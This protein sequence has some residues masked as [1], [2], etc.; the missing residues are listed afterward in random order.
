M[1]QLDMLQPWPLSAAERSALLAIAIVCLLMLWF[2]TLPAL[3]RLLAR[4][5]PRT[6]PTDAPSLLLT[7]TLTLAPR[8]ATRGTNGRFVK[9]DHAPRAPR[10]VSRARSSLL[11][12]LPARRRDV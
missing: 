10:K 3:A 9:A 6:V 11:P 12:H 1:I 2:V 5:W 8:H 4:T 7:H